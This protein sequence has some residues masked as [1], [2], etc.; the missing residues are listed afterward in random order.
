[1]KEKGEETRRLESEKEKI[2]EKAQND[3]ELQR[4]KAWLMSPS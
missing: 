1:M 4:F 2:A 3:P